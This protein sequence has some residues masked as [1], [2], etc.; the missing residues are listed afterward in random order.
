MLFYGVDPQFSWQ[1]GVPEIVCGL[2]GAR[3]IFA[4]I[5]FCIRSPLQVFVNGPLATFKIASHGIENGVIRFLFVSNIIHLNKTFHITT[6]VTKI[7][8]L[9]IIRFRGKD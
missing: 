5:F 7:T 2:Q 6:K 9:Y 1:K 8:L 3:K 4:I